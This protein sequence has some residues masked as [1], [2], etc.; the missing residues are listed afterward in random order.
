M[1][2]IDT[3]GNGP[4]LLALSTLEALN[5]DDDFMSNLKGAYSTC[6]YFSNDNNERILRQKIEKSSN[7][8]FRYHN[9]VLISRPANALIKALLFEYHDNA[10]H[11]TYRRLM[12]SLLTNF[13]CFIMTLDSKLY[14]QHCVICNRVK[15]DRRG[16]ASLQPWGIPEYPWELFGK[17]YVTDLPKSG[18][19]GHTAVFIKVCHL[20]KMAHFIPCHKEITAEE[21]AYLFISNCYIL[22]GVPKVIISDRDPKFVA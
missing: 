5:V 13:G 2:D 3:N 21:S 6:I 4:A 7:G 1:L 14:Y 16:G 9:R 8:L 15:P 11:P 12:A 19:Y 20:T 18:L 17:D 10:G 22:H